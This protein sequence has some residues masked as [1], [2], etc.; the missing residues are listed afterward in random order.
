[1]VLWVVVCIRM[2]FV[3]HGA[4][5]ALAAP[6]E[7]LQDAGKNW[8]QQLTAAG[9]SAADAPIV[10]DK[11][12]QPF[13]SAAGVGD[14]IAS[15]GNSFVDAVSSLAR[16]V[17]WTTALVPILLALLIWGLVRTRYVRRAT[18]MK[19][20]LATSGGLDVVALRSLA[21]QPVRRLLAIG[22][23]P[24]DGWRRGNA[25]I[26]TGLA[27]LELRRLGLLLP[28]ENAS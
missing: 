11:V 16:L 14:G 1:M 2:G 20:L 24:G 22:A 6:G 7:R 5:M 13:L 19:R 8:T 4:V 18:A 28:S 17:G 23:D 15:A 26:V 27:V 21:N 3:M 10:G 9:Q 12:S 25:D